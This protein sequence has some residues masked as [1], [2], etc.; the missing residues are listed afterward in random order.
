M[1]HGLTCSRTVD[2]GELQA[3]G[4]PNATLA[5]AFAAADSF[6]D[7]HTLYV[8]DPLCSPAL[9]RLTWRVRCVQ[10]AA[11]RVDIEHRAAPDT[12]D[13]AVPV[14][15]PAILCGCGSQ[16]SLSS[17]LVCSTITGCGLTSL[18]SLLPSTAFADNAE[19]LLLNLKDN[20]FTQVPSAVYA[21][22][23]L[24]TLDLEQNDITQAQLTSA[25]F[26][27]LSAL[28]ELL[29]DYD[30]FQNTNCAA[31]AV[32]YFSSN[33]EY[34]V[35]DP[36]AYASGSS[37]SSS[38]NEGSATTSQRPA[39]IA[40]T[41]AISVAIV[42]TLGARFWSI[43]SRKKRERETES[44]G[45]SRPPSPD[46]EWY[47][48]LLG[49]PDDD[50]LENVRQLLEALHLESWHRNPALVSLGRPLLDNEASS[51]WLGSYRSDRVVIRK[52][53]LDLPLKPSSCRH[54]PRFI[55]PTMLA[56]LQHPNIVRLLGVA[57]SKPLGLLVLTE[58]MDRSDLRTYL[59]AAGDEDAWWG[60]Q[61]LEMALN[62]AQALLYLHS[63]QR[64][65]HGALTAKCVLL[66]HEFTAKIGGFR[67][68]WQLPEYGAP[69]PPIP[70]TLATFDDFRSL[71][72]EV[73]M[74]NGT[75]STAL[76]MYAFGT[77]LLELDSGRMPFEAAAKRNGWS[78]GELKTQ[79]ANGKAI[80]AM[81]LSRGCPPALQLVI[82]AC[83]SPCAS[84]RP[85]ASAMVAVLRSAVA[86]TAAQ[87]S[88]GS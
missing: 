45:A 20:A 46:A 83:L 35:C 14:R 21:L 16:C 58:F 39:L 81:S 34:S 71:A 47:H 65:A 41:V 17:L 3:D 48:I 10:E 26:A 60:T 36:A 55:E 63:L 43:R 53:P 42:V 84:E 22:S 9:A 64:V 37:G 69:P 7:V 74:Q 31:G 68:A 62:V 87:S 4:A 18:D 75:A 86:H 51:L 66:D 1:A 77:V 28:D 38:A 52:V 72:P 30:A 59:R 5:V 70:S 40:G 49:D 54:D 82:R 85:S 8:A 6:R 44:S 27:F 25:Q 29:V 32:V 2:G 11:E 33:P 23:M 88:L 80:E 76:D 78:D 73:L 12:A 79:L 61:R 50:Q 19:S 67:R 57:Y 56:H 13:A 15:F 24:S